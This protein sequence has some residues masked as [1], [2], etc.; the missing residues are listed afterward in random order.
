MIKRKQLAEDLALLD[1]SPVLAITGPR[2]CGKTTLAHELSRQLKKNTIY[3]DME[4]ATD[5]NKLTDPELY[6]EQHEDK[7]LI[8]DEIQFYPDLFPLMRSAIDKKR[9]TSRFIILGSASPQLLQQSSESLAGRIIYKELS[10]FNL[11]EI[12]PDNQSKHWLRGGFPEAYL[13]GNEKNAFVWLQ[14]FINTY[15]QRDLT[16]LG[17][18]S[19]INI[20][21]RFVAMLAHGQ[22]DI[23]NQ[24]NFARS[25]GVSSPTV[26]KYLYYL[27][28]AY[29]VRVLQSYH[30]N[31]KKRLVKS[32]KVYLRDS[33]ILHHISHIITRDNLSNSVLIGAS[34]EGYVLE[35]I[36]QLLDENISPYYYRTHHGSEC[37]LVLERGNQI[38]AVLEVKYSNSPVVSKGFS[39]SISD[40]ASKRN[41]M[42]T[43]SSDDYHV[44]KDIQVCSLSTFLENYIT[45]L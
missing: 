4:S 23:F 20:F 15:I 34:W 1:L 19:S 22:G 12:G 14:N 45:T 25:L 24:N 41:F 26:K 39:I 40:L 8:I 37:D 11:L 31:T 42:L 30:F 6:F 33:G 9:I 29:I 10:P 21:M 32:P 16:R 17:Y 36:I 38:I 27:E 3:L 5:R 13:A 18:I 2:Q 28:E 35:Q 43:P 7:C 44:R